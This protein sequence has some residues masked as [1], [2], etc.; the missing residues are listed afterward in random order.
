MALGDLP[1]VKHAFP[2]E[3]HEALRRYVDQTTVGVD[4]LAIAMQAL[5][6]LASTFFSALDA[7]VAD[8]ASLHTEDTRIAGLVTALTARV[9]ALEARTLRGTTGTGTLSSLVGG[10]TSLIVTLK[11]PMPSADYIALPVIDATSG[12]NLTTV[13]ATV[14]A[15]TA[16]TVTVRISNSGIGLLQTAAVTVIAVQIA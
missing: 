4:D 9:A 11:T 14:T 16:S 15:K 2:D 12:V 6:Q 5:A 3:A 10:N 8:R 13:T 7:S 1:S